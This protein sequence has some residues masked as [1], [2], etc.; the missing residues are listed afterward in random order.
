M[1]QQCCLAVILIGSAL[2][3]VNA[4]KLLK[5]VTR[6]KDM[7]ITSSSDATKAGE[8]VLRS[9]GTAVDAMIAAQAVMGLVRPQ[10]SGIGGG[11]FA[12]YYDAD[13]AQIKTFD[14]RETSPA[15]ATEDRFQGMNFV[16]AWQSGLSVGVPGVPRLLEVMHDKY[17]KKEWSGLFQDAVDLAEN[18]F[19]F[20]PTVSMYIEMMYG[21]FGFSCVGE[22]VLFFRDP[23]AKNYF[24]SEDCTAPV[25]D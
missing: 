4:D 15:A 18:G 7:I 21:M 11:A 6:T 5:A 3:Q 23:T 9:G 16:K 8:A 19:K 2:A 17:G 22:D 20:H 10:D 25:S 24:V 12:I 14:G 13:T 1:K